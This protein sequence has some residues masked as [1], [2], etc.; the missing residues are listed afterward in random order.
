MFLPRLLLLLFTAISCGVL[1][2]LWL[3]QAAEG[4]GKP[5]TTI[6]GAGFT[7]LLPLLLV[8]H[9]RAYRRL[10]RKLLFLLEAVENNDTCIRFATDNQKEDEAERAVNQA[11]NR[12]AS[13]LHRIKQQTAQQEKYYEL[14]L[15]CAGSGILVLNSRGDVC[16]KNNEALHLLGMEVLT[17]IDQLN[18]ISPPLCQQLR[19]CCGGDTLHA[20]YNNRRGEITLTIHV[21]QITLGNQELRIIALNDIRNELDQQELDAWIRLTR[22]LIHEMMNAITP[23][24]SISDTLLQLSQGSSSLPN[25]M[26][27]GLQTISRTGESLMHFVESYRRF[28]SLPAPAPEVFGVKAFIERMV[29]LAQHQHSAQGIRFSI[30]VQPADLLLYADEKLISQVMTNLLK[31]AIQAI[32]EQKATTYSPSA[33]AMEQAS[34]EINIRAYSNEAEA[35]V[36]EISNSG[37]QIPAEIAAHIF[38]PFFSTKPQGNGIGLSISRQIMRLSQGHLRLLPGIPTTFQLTFD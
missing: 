26:T 25:E 13:M 28:T 10:T 32:G 30:A 23:I 19:S 24:T 20:S 6:L 33:R 21:R 2:T 1:W 4:C 22:V 14:I 3:L 34:G 8:W 17:H 11:L 18:R 36:I 16:Q 5:W 38:I 9:V 29:H 7:L 31:N 27:Q 37:Q 35:V 15:E 12:I